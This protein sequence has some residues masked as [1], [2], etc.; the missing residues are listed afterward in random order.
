[1]ASSDISTSLNDWASPT[2][3]NPSTI[4]DS[5][6]DWKQPAQ[7]PVDTTD[8]RLPGQPL[9]SDDIAGMDYMKAGLQTPGATLGSLKDWI[10]KGYEAL[11]GPKASLVEQPIKSATQA[12]GGVVEAPVRAIT[13]GLTAA[14]NQQNELDSEG[15]PVINPLKAAFQ[16]AIGNRQDDWST[17]L[18]D[19]PGFAE[20]V[21]PKT[22][23]SMVSTLGSVLD[24]TNDPA[25]Y[26]GGLGETT[27]G[28]EALKLGKPAAT[29][30]E[31]AEKG[32][33]YLLG[34]GTTPI[35]QGKPVLKAMTAIG[36][37]MDQVPGLGSLKQ[38]LTDWSKTTNTPFN[39]DIQNKLINPRQREA[40]IQAQKMFESDSQA[41]QKEAE[42]LAGEG[43]SKED[44][45]GIKDALNKQMLESYE[46]KGSQRS[47]PSIAGLIAQ[48]EA[49]N[50]LP[51]A[52]Q[53]I[54]KQHLDKTRAMVKQGEP[55]RMFYVEHNITPEALDFMKK[56]WPEADQK[57]FME[58]L[59]GNDS[60][61]ERGAL[62]KYTIN[63]INDKFL[64]GEGH[65]IPE[66]GHLPQFSQFRGKFF[67]DDAARVS[68]QRWL[69]DRKVNTTD[70]FMNHVG[71]TYGLSP[72]A[73]NQLKKIKGGAIQASDPA[74]MTPTELDFY[75]KGQ[76]LKEDAYA[77]FK[78]KAWITPD[79][80]EGKMFFPKEIT[81]A[82]SNVRGITESNGPFKQITS[83]L[84][85]INQFVKLMNFGV[86]PASA[87]KVE[88][89]NQALAMLNGLHSPLDQLQGHSLA[90]KYRTG[91]FSDKPMLYSK[92]LGP[93]TDRQVI[94]LAE[95]HGGI[96]MGQARAE[97]GRDELKKNVPVSAWQR[98]GQKLQGI[99]N[100]A[101]PAKM[102]KIHNFV[103]DGTRL[104]TFINALKKGYTPEGAGAV[105]RKS[106]Y[107]YS[108]LGPLDKDLTNVAPFYNFARHNM[109][110]M[111]RAWIKHPGYANALNKIQEQTNKPVKQDEANMP[112]N[113]VENNPIYAGKDKN[114]NEMYLLANHLWPANDLNEMIGSG[115]TLSEIIANTPTKMAQYAGSLLNPF[116]KEPIQQG[117]NYDMFF[118]KPIQTMPGEQGHVAGIN[119]EMPVRLAHA[120]NQF[121]PVAEVG[122]LNN[123]NLPP[124]ARVIRALTG[125]NIRS[126][127]PTEGMIRKQHSEKMDINKAQEQVNLQKK[128]YASRLENNDQQGAKEAFINWQQAVKNL[129]NLKMKGGD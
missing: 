50:K 43:A 40:P 128:I 13:S 31:G 108:E 121:R 127:N 115:K 98:A 116:I 45:Q 122:R 37:G 16:G 57:K 26:V 5:L 67:D 66:L 60:S 80:P 93:L 86:Y 83:S 64:K 107:D 52:M 106:L 18:R 70:D 11:A 109:E 63:E 49:I 111:M 89:G 44:I 62:G 71:K 41:I 85:P 39:Y 53:D 99:Q 22:K 102:L 55:N 114:G 54:A 96:N 47:M 84:R 4:N 19:M 35:I 29:L 12:L 77:S 87:V 23:E 94:Q 28:L 46:P 95:K 97:L 88:L 119:Q 7:P 100:M 105:T 9:H 118:K 56:Q 20:G 15:R 68:A 27:K 36:Q 42:R 48:G 124:M 74:R 78:D 25:M 120:L 2:N 34:M 82:L 30:G 21:T 17:V 38:S 51:P 59:V 58:S 61:L 129:N 81:G 75:N 103:E 24:W 73:W 6:S 112:E 126:Y 72:Q 79:N 32:E 1:M 10:V 91:K 123:E 3:S 117:L 14:E 110:G 76:G 33:R 125:A 8:T 90:W 65:H 69:E 113:M 104:G 92:T 101:Y